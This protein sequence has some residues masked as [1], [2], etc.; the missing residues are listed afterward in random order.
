MGLDQWLDGVEYRPNRN[1]GKRQIIKTL[2]GSFY[3]ARQIHEYILEKNPDNG[4]YCDRIELTKEQLE[5]IVN[6]FN[7]VLKNKDSASEV[8]PDPY[9]RYDEFYFNQI[10]EFV[11]VCMTII[12][13][14]GYEW[15]EYSYWG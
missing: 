15:S 1:N 11:D 2:E 3:N 7:G 5:D 8:L 9:E 14:D 4:Y 12:N 10:K 13:N 6:V